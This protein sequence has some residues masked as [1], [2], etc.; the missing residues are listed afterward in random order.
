MLNII[1]ELLAPSITSIQDHLNEAKETLNLKQ[2]KYRQACYEAHD[3]NP[4]ALKAQIQA[5]NIL[6]EATRRVTELENTL[7][8]AI[9]NQTNAEIKHEQDEQAK[10]KQR[11]SK[12]ADRLSA[13][14]TKV[15]IAASALGASMKEIADIS[16]ELGSL[17]PINSIELDTLFKHLLGKNNLPCAI[18][19]TDPVNPRPDLE[20][21]LKEAA[22]GIKSSIK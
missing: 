6:D 10:L 13:T 20:T 3:G 7:S 21:K 2:D 9:A 16:D 11:M 14:A 12:L 1:S 15:D 4:A 17:A 8:V 22:Q 5:Q 18:S 19:W